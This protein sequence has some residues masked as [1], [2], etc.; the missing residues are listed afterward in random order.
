[1]LKLTFKS[2]LLLRRFNTRQLKYAK[3]YI[4]YQGPY[5]CNNSR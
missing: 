3:T 5:D 2:R 4:N 1:M